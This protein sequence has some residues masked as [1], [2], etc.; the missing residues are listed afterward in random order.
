MSYQLK[1]IKY[2]SKYSALKQKAGETNLLESKT[3][4]FIYSLKN[5]TPIY[6]LSPENARLVLNNIQLSESYKRLVQI[7]DLNI[8]YENTHLNLSIFR[9][10]GENKILSVV[11]YFHGGGWIL[12]SNQ[13]HGRL[14]S[15]IA[16]E[17]NTAVVFVNYTLAPESSYPT[18]LTQCYL[19]TKYIIENDLKHNLNAFK[20]VVAGDSVG[21]GFATVVAMTVNKSNPIISYQVLMY[22]VTSATMDTE[23]YKIYE[24]GPWLSKK[25][26]Q[27]FYNA[28]EPNMEKRLEKEISPLAASNED[29]KHSPPGLIITD[30]NDVLRDEGEAYAHKLL[31]LGI[32]ITAVRYLGTIHDFLLLDPLQDTPAAISARNLICFSIKTALQNDSTVY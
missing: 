12:G 13:T 7:E 18:Q 3:K 22:P 9:P 23:S 25:S 16:T 15:Q 27:W 1:Y 26:M 29:L 21:G 32:S 28:Y 5:A 30:E 31:N 24:N 10:V 14:V 4:D 8:V 20:M 11:M 19:A 2:K 6:Q 17:T